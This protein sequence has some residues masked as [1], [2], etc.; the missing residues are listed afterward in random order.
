[1]QRSLELARRSLG[2]VSPNPAVGAVVVREGKIV[3]E[4]RTQPPGGDHA[5]IVA[6]RDAGDLV[7]GAEL[8]ITL[9]PCSQFGRTPPCTEAIAAAGISRVH[10]AAIDPNP[11]ENGRGMDWL[12]AAGVGISVTENESDALAA[13][14]LMAAYSKHSTTGRPYVTSKFAM[15]LDGK[16]ATRMGSSTWITGETARAHAHV[17]RAESDA[18]LVGIGTVVAD[19][20][21]LT[22]RDS[23]SRPLAHQPLRVVVDSQCSV[24]LDAAVTSDG[25]RT[26]IACVSVEA[27]K[28][29]ELAAR[30]VEVVVL[31]DRTGRVDLDALMTLLGSRGVTSVLVEGGGRIAGSFFDA[32]MVDRV[33]AYIAPMIVGG[34]EAP[35][36]VGGDGAEV[37]ADALRL[38]ECTWEMLGSDLI[39]IGYPA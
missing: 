18:V 26:L 5:E 13:S 30:G 9:E 15:S 23:D 36:P 27:S 39:V 8:F 24:P 20:P 37:V 22:A 14:R 25:G 1:M 3:G 35:G 29:A 4:G 11:A 10:V 34:R 17:L 2:L 31:P 19:D 28:K 12:R 38:K 32:D 16:I 6:I 33:A 7:R 21:R